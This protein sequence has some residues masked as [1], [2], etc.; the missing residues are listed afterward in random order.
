MITA[1]HLCIC[2]FFIDGDGS[3]ELILSV[4]NLSAAICRTSFKEG[5]IHRKHIYIYF[6][7]SQS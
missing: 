5:G 4:I 2:G 6:I 7:L 3:N 1:V